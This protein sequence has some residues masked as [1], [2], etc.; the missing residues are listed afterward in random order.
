MFQN[1]V[2]IGVLRMGRDA[3]VEP[4]FRQGPVR[5][6]GDKGL[7]QFHDVVAGPVVRVDAPVGPHSEAVEVLAVDED[8]GAH[9]QK[10]TRPGERA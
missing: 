2:P 7:S 6:P 9:M 3:G 4:H 5:E 10:N 8:Q 1:A